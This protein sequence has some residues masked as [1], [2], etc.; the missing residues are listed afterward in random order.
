MIKT[1]VWCI[2]LII[3]SGYTIIEMISNRDQF[4]AKVIL[5]FVFAYLAYLVA[6]TILKRK[7]IAFSITVMTFL[8]FFVFQRI[9]WLV[10]AMSS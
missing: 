1:M 5:F 6:E 7:K 4:V 8:S 9:A 10:I 2:Q 3:W